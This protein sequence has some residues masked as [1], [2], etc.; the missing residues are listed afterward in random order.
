MLAILINKLYL[1]VTGKKVA[2]AFVF[3]IAFTI[4]FQIINAKMQAH[5]KG[6]SLLDFNTSYNASDAYSALSN[7]GSVG[8][9]W[10]IVI[11]LV[12]FLYITSYV[13]FFGM[14]MAY[15]IAKAGYAQSKLR[16]VVIFPLLL[17]LVDILENVCILAVLI[18]YPMHLIA[19]ADSAGMLTQVKFIMST[20]NLALIAI[21]LIIFGRAKLVKNR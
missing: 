10:H 18:L 17:G 2:L 8:R 1:K 13:L 7:Y 3:Y 15:I 20:I 21:T 9:V 4:L 16:F 19:V 12:D 6:A 5:F 11:D 14:F